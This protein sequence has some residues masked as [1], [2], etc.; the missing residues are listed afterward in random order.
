MYNTVYHHKAIGWFSSWTRCR[1]TRGDLWCSDLVRLFGRDAVRSRAA[2]AA[3]RR[4]RARAPVRLWVPRGD[5]RSLAVQPDWR[6]IN[7]NWTGQLIGLSVWLFINIY[8]HTCFFGNLVWIFINQ[9]DLTP[10]KNVQNKQ[11]KIFTVSAQW[12][13][14]T[15]EPVRIH[16]LPESFESTVELLSNLPLSTVSVIKVCFQILWILLFHLVSYSF[17]LSFD[18]TLFVQLWKTK[19]FS[20]S[21]QTSDRFPTDVLG[22]MVIC[23]ILIKGWRKEN[24]N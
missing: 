5:G 22:T 1:C 6:L 14:A 18:I 10:S 8:E 24:N 3:L 19:A 16:R 23:R 2:V 21:S 13:W 12:G 17:S 7:G 4:E 20:R 11:H 15:Q 9:K